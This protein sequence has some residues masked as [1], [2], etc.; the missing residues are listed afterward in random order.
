MFIEIAV[1]DEAEKILALQ[2][3]AY[4]TEGRLYRNPRL[5]PL[6]QT[7]GEVREAIETQLVLKAVEEGEIVGS[8]RA[9]MEGDACLIGRLIVRPDR[10]GRGIGKRLMQ[11]VEA[12]FPAAVRFKLFTGHLSERALRLYSGLGY[13]ECRR[14][15]VN[16]D[17]TFIY[18][19]KANPGGG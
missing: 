8:V 15:V 11:E 5:P 16:D 14:E 10:Q 12:R 18:L 17:L 4:A 19:E 1:P 2:K 6:A 3:A 13:E 7:A 9:L